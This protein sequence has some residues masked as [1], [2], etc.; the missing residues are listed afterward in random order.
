MDSST[1]RSSIETLQ[2]SKP[3]SVNYGTVV[4]DVIKIMKKKRIG[5]VCVVQNDELV[6]IFTE[7]DVLTKVVGSDAEIEKVRVESV[8]TP[9][10]EYLFQDDRIAYALNR[11][12]VG[13]FRHIPLINF[14][15]NPTGII[16]VKEIFACLIK[17]LNL[18]N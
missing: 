5:C 10:P 2:P 15:G 12:H 18:R 11:M 4:S 7:R 6:G 16:S 1:L 9:S 3:I 14:Q 8:M 13:G 17:N